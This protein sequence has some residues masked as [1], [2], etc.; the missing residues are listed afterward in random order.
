MEYGTWIF[1]ALLLLQK[2]YASP[3]LALTRPAQQA[4]GAKC[5]ELQPHEATSSSTGGVD[6][7]CMCDG[8]MT[9]CALPRMCILICCC[10]F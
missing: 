7:T 3:A 6:I 2:T 5:F 4:G 9:I 8:E 1:C 10:W